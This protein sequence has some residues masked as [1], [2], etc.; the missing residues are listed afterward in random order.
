LKTYGSTS[1]IRQIFSPAICA[2]VSSC[3]AMAALG[4]NK[5]AAN[6]DSEFSFN[7]GIVVYTVLRCAWQKNK[8]TYTEMTRFS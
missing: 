1:G 8:K 3:C 7:E 6:E 2:A 4:V 5:P